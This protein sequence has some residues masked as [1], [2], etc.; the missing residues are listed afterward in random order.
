MK[1]H[2]FIISILFLLLSLFGLQVVHVCRI[3]NDRDV[4]VQRAKTKAGKLPNIGQ[5]LSAH[6]LVYKP[7]GF[8]IYSRR[9]TPKK[10]VVGFY[11]NVSVND[12][13]YYVFNKYSLRI[14]YHG[15]VDYTTK[16]YPINFNNRTNTN[17]NKTSEASGG[18]RPSN[19][20]LFRNFPE[21]FFIVC[22]T[23]HPSNSS[24][25]NVSSL[26][27]LEP[28][29]LYPLST[30]DMCVDIKFGDE[31][32]MHAVHMRTGLM[33]P[34]LLAVAFTILALVAVIHH[35]KNSE[36]VRN[37]NRFNLPHRT[38][39]YDYKMSKRKLNDQIQLVK[40]AKWRSEYDEERSSNQEPIEEVSHR[41]EN[42]YN[43]H[44]LNNSSSFV[45]NEFQ[46]MFY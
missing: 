20:L 14:R 16:K 6:D 40:Y 11:F 2:F 44:I 45:G 34:L 19:E 17:S 1:I 12:S 32:L 46:A 35:F 36:L 43:L 41:I 22:A 37:Y 24:A 7:S 27:D 31:Y 23:L 10:I 9:L 26:S 5:H 42:K 39:L 38:K 33:A 28:A 3:D 18:A 13:Y 8:E 15:L 4:A 30:S 29:E 25:I 21:T